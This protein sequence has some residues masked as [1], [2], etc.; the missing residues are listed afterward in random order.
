MTYWFTEQWFEWRCSTNFCIPSFNSFRNL[1][2]RVRNV[3]A[4]LL[5]IEN[6]IVIV[7]VADVVWSISHQHTRNCIR[8][9]PIRPPR[10]WLHPFYV[11]TSKVCK[12]KTA[13][14]LSLVE[15]SNT[16]NIYSNLLLIHMNFALIVWLS[17]DNS[18]FSFDELSD[19]I[20]G[21]VSII[22]IQMI[23]A[24]MCK[25]KEKS[26]HIFSVGHVSRNIKLNLTNSTAERVL[27]LLLEN[28]LFCNFKLKIQNRL[29]ILQWYDH[30]LTSSSRNSLVEPHTCFENQYRDC[31]AGRLEVCSKSRVYENK[32]VSSRISY[33]LRFRWI[34]SNITLL[35]PPPIV[36]MR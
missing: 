16:E 21:H 9:M 8:T 35:Y 3:L 19:W 1:F 33:I 5:W 18:C 13:N 7:V 30:Q 28:H 32:G 6:H 27:D 11:W 20:P 31:C 36:E 15:H 22:C 29:R 23:I 25:T 34:N 4:E 2:M 17:V 14:R 10:S 24:K 12:L 26:T